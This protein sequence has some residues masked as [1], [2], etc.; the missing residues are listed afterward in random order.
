V[1]PRYRYTCIE[2]G[3]RGGGVGADWQ[4]KRG[5]GGGAAGG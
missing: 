4:N 1:H 3:S 2:A 5:E